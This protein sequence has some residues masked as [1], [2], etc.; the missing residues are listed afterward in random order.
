MLHSRNKHFD[1]A[2]MIRVERDRLGL[3]QQQMA[4]LGCV[5]KRSQ[6]GYEAG[7]RVPDLRY[8]R[9]VGLGGIDVSKLIFGDMSESKIPKIDWQAHDEILETIEVW[10][11]SNQLKLPFNRKMDLLRL[12]L[13][14]F[15]LIHKI[16]REFI[17]TTLKE[18]A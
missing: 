5:S 8:L 1:F 3:T 10:L 17:I 18:A 4:D 13:S 12:F 6:V 15:Q 2:R 7:A 11:D 9:N 16:D 14:H